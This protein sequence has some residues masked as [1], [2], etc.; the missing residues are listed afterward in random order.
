MPPSNP[1]TENTSK[2]RLISVLVSAAFGLVGLVLLLVFVSIEPFETVSKSIEPQDLQATKTRPVRLSDA[3]QK[4]SATRQNDAKTVEQ[5]KLGVRRPDSEIVFFAP[6]GSGRGE[7]GRAEAFESAPEG[8]MSFVVDAQGRTLVLDQVNSRVVVFEQGEPVKEIEIP[9]ATYQ[10]LKLDND[11]N[12]ILLDR[13]AQREITLL[14]LDGRVISEVN[15]EGP[16]VREG[17]AVTALFSRADGIWVEVEHRNLV[18]LSDA[19]GSAVDERSQVPG[20]FWGE[21]DSVLTV[22][23]E[24]PNSAV[25]AV[26]SVSA[27]RT[28]SRILSRVLFSMRIMH[29]LALESDGAGRIYLAAHL[30]KFRQTK[31]Y[32]V[33]EEN[34][35]VVLLSS[36][37]DE[38]DRIRLPASRIALEQ[39]R[40]LFVGADGMMYQL[41]FSEE[42]ATLRKVVL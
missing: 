1:I 41:A 7:L 37:G 42:G 38:L 12:L 8:P 33:I 36:G 18:R 32:D 31:P 6:W 5:E 15:L 19:T 26:Q 21:S 17:G 30:V 22:A 27:S 28:D 29:L 24:G 39:F 3:K 2:K 40:S 23:R 11:G 10:E 35:E 14:D 25:V 9:A 34:I 4:N 16:G 13:L 20:R